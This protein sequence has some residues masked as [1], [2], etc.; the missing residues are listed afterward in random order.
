MTIPEL[1][2]LPSGV[3]HKLP[4]LFSAGFE[5]EF[6][7]QNP[8]VRELLYAVLTA[9]GFIGIPVDVD[10]YLLCCLVSARRLGVFYAFAKDATALNL[11]AL[12]PV[13]FNEAYQLEI[14]GGV[15]ELLAEAR[16]NG[17]PTGQKF[18]LLRQLMQ[19]A[20]NT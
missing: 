2:Q 9:N 3:L 17:L 8:E 10:G 1:L 13:K 11:L 12:R 5:R 16:Q 7:A 15:E 20:A 19:E 6:A 4:I 18:A 14:E